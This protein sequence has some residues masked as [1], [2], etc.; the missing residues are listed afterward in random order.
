MM[1]EPDVGEVDVC[2][3]NS[4]SESV[5][6]RG[7]A[8]LATSNKRCRLLRGVPEPCNLVGVGGG[9]LKQLKLRCSVYG[10]VWKSD[11]G[12]RSRILILR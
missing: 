7:R 11:E 1:A 4:S 3:R 2:W 8:I 9:L 10:G 6:L 5:S 12:D